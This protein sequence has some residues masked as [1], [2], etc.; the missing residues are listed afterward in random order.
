[1]TIPR[2]WTTDTFPITSTMYEKLAWK[3]RNRLLNGWKIVKTWIR[4]C[5]DP[6]YMN[7]VIPR[8]RSFENTDV[9]NTDRHRIIFRTIEIPTRYKRCSLDDNST[10][11]DPVTS[12]RCLNV[13]DVTLSRTNHKFHRGVPGAKSCPLNLQRSWLSQWKLSRFHS[14]D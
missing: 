9:T 2:V 11:S 8:L 10:C 3:V 13:N 12:I 14:A 1:M 5:R 6:K 4:S 7:K